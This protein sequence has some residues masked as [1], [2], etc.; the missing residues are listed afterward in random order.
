MRSKRSLLSLAAIPVAYLA[1]FYIYPLATILITGLFPD[2]RFALSAFVD[3]A[4]DPAVRSVAWFTLWQAV[5]STLLTLL[6]G[7]PGAY[8]FAR[9]RFPG[10]SLLRSIT[11]VPFVLPTV[12]VGVAFLAV[13]GPGSPLG[14]DLRGSIWAILI[15]HVFYNLSIVIRGVGVFWEQIDP[16][17]EEAARTLGAGRT[18]VFRSIVTINWLWSREISRNKSRSSNSCKN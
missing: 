18:R 17:I 1:Y 10:R 13:L 12:V 15:A 16:R 9:Y 11:L 4:T 8:V 14:I 7:V 2:G 3:V 5:L 6:L